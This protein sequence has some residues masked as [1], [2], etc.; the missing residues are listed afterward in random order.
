MEKRLKN[1]F[2][3]EEDKINKITKEINVIE[4][5]KIKSELA[6]VLL[7]V[8]NN[9]LDKLDRKF[10]VHKDYDSYR[11]ILLTRKETAESI[12]RMK[13]KSL[14]GA[15]NAVFNAFKRLIGK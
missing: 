2:K 10:K 7:I 14:L 5:I 3:E 8:V 6:E 4:N 12:I 9:A 1:V 11:K 15:I 13:E